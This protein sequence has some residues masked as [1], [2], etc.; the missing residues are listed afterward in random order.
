M[1]A[2]Q[3][4]RGDIAYISWRDISSIAWRGYINH[5]IRRR[6]YSRS[7]VL[8][9]GRWLRDTDLILFTVSVTMFCV[10]NSWTAHCNFLP[11]FN[12]L[13]LT[14]LHM[15]KS[16]LRKLIEIELSDKDAKLSEVG[17]RKYG[18]SK[19]GFCQLQIL[20]VSSP[21]SLLTTQTC[22]RHSIFH[23]IRF[24]ECSCKTWFSCNTKGDGE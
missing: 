18:W 19:G 22:L 5:V 9:G 3:L 15:P 8:V 21:A 17:W 14:M 12:S 24:W 16:D 6:N 20:C 4:F 11:A 23:E 10:A 13:T 1:N 2:F 7:V